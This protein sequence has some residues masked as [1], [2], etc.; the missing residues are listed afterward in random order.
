MY[1]IEKPKFFP[2]EC[3]CDYCIMGKEFIGKIMF[4]NRPLLNRTCCLYSLFSGRSFSGKSTIFYLA[5]LFEQKSNFW[6]ITAKTKTSIY[7]DYTWNFI[8]KGHI[9]IWKKVYAKYISNLFLEVLAMY[10]M[11][12]SYDTTHNNHNFPCTHSSNGFVQKWQ[13]TSLFLPG[14]SHEQRSLVGYSP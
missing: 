5:Y 14:E 9:Y 10:I 7:S 2:T 11:P 4:F 1:F 13:P 8:H 3:I 6:V 12:F